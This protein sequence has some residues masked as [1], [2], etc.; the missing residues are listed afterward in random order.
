M[1]AQAAF[2]I[3]DGVEHIEHATPWQRV[4]DSGATP[5]LLSISRTVRSFHWPDPGPVLE[6]DKL[7]SE[8]NVG[9]FDVLVL[10][11]GTAGPDFLRGDKASVTFVR[12][13][14]ATGRPVAAICHAPWVLLEAGL[15]QGRRMTSWPTLRTDLINA[16]AVWVDESL[17]VDRGVITSRNPGDLQDFWLL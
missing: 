12:D 4:L 5:T 11:G 2:L 6:V 13:F 1:G 17:V 15:A 3:A 7:V 10:P 14:A 8:A 16:G 9:D